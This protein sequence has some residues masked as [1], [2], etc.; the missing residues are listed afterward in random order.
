MTLAFQQEGKEEGEGSRKL[1]ESGRRV[2]SS[3][4]VSVLDLFEMVYVVEHRGSA[5]RG[6]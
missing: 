1:R 4:A 2:E 5:W 3:P 6:S